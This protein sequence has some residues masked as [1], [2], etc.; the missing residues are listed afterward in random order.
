[1]TIQTVKEVQEY[2]QKKN[3][4]GVLSMLLSDKVWLLPYL[5]SSDGILEANN[6]DLQILKKYWFDSSADATL[7][8]KDVRCVFDSYDYELKTLIES[9]QFEYNP[10]DNV[11]GTTTTIHKGSDI[12]KYDEKSNRDL[13]HDI[14]RV[15]DSS[16]LHTGTDNLNDS[17][18]AQTESHN[19]GGTA[20]YGKVEKTSS[21]THTVSPED[22]NTM[23]NE[24][25]DSG[26]E[27]TLAR[28]DSTSTQGGSTIE[29]YT[30]THN[31]TVNLKDKID[32]TENESLDG[33]DKFAR[34]FNDVTTTSYSDTVVRIGNI[35]VTSTQQL[36]QQ[37][38][39][40]AR[41]NICE[42]IRDI[43]VSNFCMMLYTEGASYKNWGC[44]NGNY[45]L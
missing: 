5:T 2:Y 32:G 11:N 15:T 1:M 18:G 7:L 13:F 6:G 36:I 35:G 3:N 28:T 19:D 8:L 38:R 27:T 45:L 42:R 41:F 14:N 4:K 37:Q 24:S 34:E 29:A 20:N 16:N 22:T 39:D 25:G 43:F 10:I 26:N 31:R 33:N 9:T 44:E 12:K 17:Y 30:D 21:N 23:Y 40:I